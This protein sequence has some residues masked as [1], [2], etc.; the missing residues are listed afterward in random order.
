LAGRGRARRGALTVRPGTGAAEWVVQPGVRTTGRGAT[1]PTKLRQR[2]GRECEEGEREL[3]QGREGESSAVL[4]IE[5][6]GERRGRRGKERPSGVG[7]LIDGEEEVREREKRE[8]REKK[9]PADSSAPLVPGAEGARSFASARAGR[10]GA[11]CRRRA[12]G[13]GEE[14]TRGWAPPVIERDGRGNWGGGAWALVG[15]N[16]LCG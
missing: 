7:F 9:T 2:R 1:G 6:E 13:A 4:F 10:G 8:G 15:R 12:P 14:E 3:G 5:R 11:A 16:G